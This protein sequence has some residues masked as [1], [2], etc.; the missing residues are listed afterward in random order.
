MSEFKNI[1][2]IREANVYFEGKVTSRTVLFEDG[3]K[4]TLGFM[5][6]GEYSFD[7]GAAEVMELLGGSMN[8][9]LPDTTDWKLFNAGESFDVPANSRFELQ[10]SDFCD[11]CCSYV[12][13]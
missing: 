11:Y 3:T 10:V 5:Q 8:V 7:T 1:T 9:L 13:N 2:I 12:A 4:K 6:P